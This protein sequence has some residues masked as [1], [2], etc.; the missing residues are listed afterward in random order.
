ML[1]EAPTVQDKGNEHNFICH[2]SLAFRPQIIQPLYLMATDGPAHL[3]ESNAVLK[4]SD[5]VDL[6]S[7][8]SLF[9]ILI[10]QHIQ[11]HQSWRKSAEMEYWQIF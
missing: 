1:V 6:P 11:V 8:S 4:S 10:M 3:F 5:S 9:R 7:F 2:Q